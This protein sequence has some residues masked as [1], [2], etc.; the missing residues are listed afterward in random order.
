MLPHTPPP[1]A[2]TLSAD[3][4]TSPVGDLVIVV[5]GNGS[6]RAI[7]FRGDDPAAAVVA[8]AVEGEE[9][10]RWDPEGCRVVAAQLA[11][12]FQGRRRTFGVPLAPRGTDFERRVWAALEAIPYGGVTSY[13][14]LARR[15]GDRQLV[16]AVGRANGANPISILVPCH[17]VIGADGSLVGYGGG[18]AAKRRLLELEGAMLP[19]LD[20]EP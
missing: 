1:T 6:V 5:D 3:L 20:G 4:V 16:R 17:R 15:L 2:K 10:V 9:T 13:G 7:L 14:E 19:G 12:Y 18:L 11:E 8:G